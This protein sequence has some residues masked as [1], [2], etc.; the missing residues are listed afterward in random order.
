MNAD[1]RPVL[2]SAVSV[3]LL[4]TSCSK[5]E[6]QTSDKR[7]T[8]GDAITRVSN[9]LLPAVVEK[10]MLGQPASIPERMS[11]YGVPG[12]SIA[13]IDGGE[14]AWERSFGVAGGQ[15]PVTS[16]TMFQAA[17][18]SKPVTA[19]AALILAQDGLI[20]LDDEANILLQS[21][22]IPENDFT[23]ERPVTVRGL[24][25]HTS[26]FAGNNG[27]I[28]YMP[29][30]SIPTLIQSL[31]GEPPSKTGPVEVAVPVGKLSYSGA[32]YAV[33]QQLIIDV[34]GEPFAD[35]MK[36]AVLLPLG[37]THSTF[38]Q[39]PSEEQ[40]SKGHHAGG[41]RIAGGYR[42]HSGE[43]AAGLWSTPSDLAKFAV[44]IQQAASGTPGTLLTRETVAEMLRP[45]MPECIRCWGLGVE[46]LGEWPDQW[47]TH[48]G[49]NVGFDSKL[50]AHSSSGDGA[51][52]MTNGS[53]SFGLIY[54]ILDSIA[55]EYDW[56]DYTA[57]GQ[58]EAVPIPAEALETIPGDYELEPDFAVSIIADNERL[59]FEIPTQGRTELYASSPD[60]FF[61]TALDWGPMTFVSDE[62]GQVTDMMI[63]H[64]GQQSSHRRLR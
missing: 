52:V 18:I 45:Q 60:S 6:Q 33:L 38:D 39:A 44:S 36:K 13:V 3:L 57:K 32:G 12:L 27:V 30:S 41:E 62:S 14:L 11:H 40:I 1:I 17:S 35:Y 64:P 58:I 61:I 42:V 2:V 28:D 29:G 43:A 56:P 26:G 4:A 23:R 31:N 50:L 8:G 49:I 47:F 9:G 7:P 19:A 22:T 5:P 37:M 55:R 51:V 25:S 10:G 16:R 34:S 59:F 46:L 15:D 21:W 63:G 54:E 48:D 24:L 20:D 53:L